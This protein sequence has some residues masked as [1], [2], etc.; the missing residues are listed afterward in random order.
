[1]SVRQQL[2][3]VRS[4]S[5]AIRRKDKLERQQFPTRAHDLGDL[6]KPR[7]I[8]HESAGLVT[9]EIGFVTMTVLTTAV[10]Y[11]GEMILMPGC[12][13]V[14]NEGFLV[15]RANRLPYHSLADN[16]RDAYAEVLAAHRR[17]DSLV[18]QFGGKEA[19]K[20]AVNQAPWHQMC[21]VSD[22]Y[23]AGMCQWGVNSFL[24]RFRAVH[25]ASWTGLPNGLLR[26]A[27]SYGERIVAASLLRGS[28]DRTLVAIE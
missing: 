18:D 1:M 13:E 7:W 4:R 22:A 20:L 19:L 27:G 28:R 15:F 11:R 2:R 8:V 12:D 21:T 17:A 10:H 5:F 9:T 3:A 26:F 25:I 6:I 24:R 14:G 16:S 23:N